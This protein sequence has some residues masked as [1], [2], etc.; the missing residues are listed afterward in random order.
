MNVTAAK[1]HA[2]ERFL[3]G[4]PD[5]AQITGSLTLRAICLAFLRFYPDCNMAKLRELKY[6]V[7]Y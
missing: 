2:T 1:P 3:A 6:L 7:R 5:M 4:S